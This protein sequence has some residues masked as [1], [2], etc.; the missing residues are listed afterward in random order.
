VEAGP[1]PPKEVSL[2]LFLI[3]GAEETP[4]PAHPPSH[5]EPFRLLFAGLPPTGLTVGTL[6]EGRV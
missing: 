4:T 6:A 2:N 5:G 3:T 1:P